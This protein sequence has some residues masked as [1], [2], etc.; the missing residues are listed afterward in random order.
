ML[1]IAMI[2]PDLRGHGRSTNP[3]NKFTHRQSAL[4]VCALLDELKIDKF[5]GMGISTGGMTLIHM[6]TQQPERAEAIVL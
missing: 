4:D 2:I 3:T 1:C 6:A 5:G